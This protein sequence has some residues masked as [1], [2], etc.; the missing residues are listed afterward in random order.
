MTLDEFRN[1]FCILYDNVM[2]NQAPELTDYEISVFL[3][4]AQEQIV[5]AYASPALNVTREDYKSNPFRE[6][7]YSKL[8][9]TYSVTDKNNTSIS[10]FTLPNNILGILNESCIVLKSSTPKT[11]VVT[12]LVAGVE[13][14]RLLS[15][16]YP[17]PLKGYAWRVVDTILDSG[18]QYYRLIVDPSHTLKSYSMLYLKKPTPI[19]LD[20]LSSDQ[21]TIDGI[22]IATDCIL[23]EAIHRDIVQRAVELA[24]ATYKGDLSTQL[25]LKGISQTEIGIAN[26][27]NNNR[28]D[29]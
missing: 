12:P 17:Y 24:A 19:I 13:K 7:I 15:K 2:S 16:P 25:Q 27:V 10:S 23:P 26:Q 3:T 28:N 20:D 6:H 14:D 21:L 5:K 4:K 29:E 22:G 18:E 9:S 8:L 11:L 1:E